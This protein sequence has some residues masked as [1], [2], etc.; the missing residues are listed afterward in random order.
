MAGCAVIVKPSEE[1]P[2]T[3]T[4]LGDASWH[5]E[6]VARIEAWIRDS[7]AALG[8]EAGGHGDFAEAGPLRGDTHIAQRRHL[9]AD[10]SILRLTYDLKAGFQTKDQDQ[11]FADHGVIVNDEDADGVRH[12]T[13]H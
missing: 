5:R 11:S 2:A 9:Q 3:A 8:H 4:L 7:A 1:T 6:L 10:A 13:I 12:G